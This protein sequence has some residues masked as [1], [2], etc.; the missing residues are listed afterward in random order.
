[1]P[2]PQSG[3]AGNLVPPQAPRTALDADLA[4]PGEA[5]KLRAG[6]QNSGTGTYGSTKVK[7]F[8]PPAADTPDSEKKPGWVEVVLADEEGNPVSGEPYQITLPDGSVAQGTL[9]ATGFV[10]VEG[11]DP[12]DCQITFPN[13]DASAWAQK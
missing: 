11:F 1:M 5:A 7:L 12:G 13:R 8:V 6:Q 3:T 4:N 9:D 10:R 2:S